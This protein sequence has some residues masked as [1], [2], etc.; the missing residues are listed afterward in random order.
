MANTY[1]RRRIPIVDRR[2]Q[3]KY[4][5][6][7]VGVAAVVSTILGA[8]LLRSYWEMNEVV[9]LASVNPDVGE[10]LN[11]GDARFVF[12]VTVVFL[13]LEVFGLGFIG[14]LITHKVV[15]PVFVLHR[16]L[17]S[18]VEGIYPNTRPLRTG[19]EFHDMF[20]SFTDMVETLRQ[21]DADDLEKLRVVLAGVQQKGLGTS[22]MATLQALID[23]RE[24]RLKPRTA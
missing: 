22:E 19:D 7:I 12:R 3:F 17:R 15:G 18:I 24:T 4:T 9:G 8:L 21:R 10:Q 14:L 1:Q 16:H 5:A 6:M 13:V 20:T 23:E 11:N 2:F